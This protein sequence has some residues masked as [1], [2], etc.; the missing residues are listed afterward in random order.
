MPSW[1]LSVRLSVEVFDFVLQRTFLQIEPLSTVF[2]QAKFVF[3][4]YSFVHRPPW[5][6]VATSRLPVLR[7]ARGATLL[8]GHGLRGG[9]LAHETPPAARQQLQLEGSTAAAAR[10]RWFGARAGCSSWRVG[11]S[12]SR[13]R[14]CGSLPW[15]VGC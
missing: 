8:A 14:T 11:S 4:L 3:N 15:R 10:A 6:S 13:D 2:F 5:V 9:G 12:H 7:G 1:S